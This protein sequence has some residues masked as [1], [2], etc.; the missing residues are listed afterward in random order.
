[1]GASQ[2][3]GKNKTQNERMTHTRWPYYSLISP[4]DRCIHLAVLILFPDGVGMY[5]VEV[6]DIESG[7]GP[8]QTSF[9]NKAKPGFA[10]RASGVVIGFGSRR[11]RQRG[12]TWWYLR[13]LS[14]EE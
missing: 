7:S 6:E 8:A 1:M 9:R 4:A 12:R 11:Y 14:A 13:W 2:A 5:Q 10:F 3:A